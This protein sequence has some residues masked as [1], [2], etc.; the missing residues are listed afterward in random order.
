M[1]TAGFII[2]ENTASVYVELCD[3]GS[4]EDLFKTYA[5]RRLEAKENGQQA[6]YIPERFIWHAFLGL[7]DGLAYL[8]GGKEY[9]K[10]KSKDTS[11]A[12]GW[13]PILHRDLKPD[14]VLFRSRET[15]G[16]NKYPYCVISD[17]GLACEDWNDNHPNVDMHQKNRIRLGTCNYF[18]PELC[19]S[20]FPDLANMNLPEARFFPNGNKHTEKSDLWALGA[21]I[22]NIAQCEAQYQNGDPIS[23]SWAHICAD[24]KPGDTRT[25]EEFF[26][27]KKSRKQ[28]LPIKSRYSKQ[29]GK[30]IHLATQ[31]DPKN[32]PTCAQMVFKMQDLMKEA[33][34]DKMTDDDRDALPQWALRAH[35]FYAK[36]KPKGEKKR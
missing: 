21:S 8:R 5:L 29:L 2:P 32:R 9:S 25:W 4:M 3:K 28:V 33:G 18:A 23:E 15:L 24:A 6:P 13:A 10:L 1:Y 14:N 11:P 16:S 26:N 27:G 35:D 19:Y 31:W 20:E 30:A 7:C 12:K 17:F 36:N 34:M 22:Y